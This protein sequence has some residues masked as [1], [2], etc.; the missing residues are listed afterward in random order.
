MTLHAVS[1]GHPAP[2]IGKIFLAGGLRVYFAWIHALFTFIL[3]THKI[4]I[5]LFIRVGYI[6]HC[7]DGSF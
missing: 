6:W 3:L 7:V 5:I 2:L 4:M 1:R